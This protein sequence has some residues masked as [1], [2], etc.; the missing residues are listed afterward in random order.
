MKT[1]VA[2]LVAAILLTSSLFSMAPAWGLTV[3][4]TEDC[5]SRPTR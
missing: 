1:V 2:F 5:I 3:V 4:C